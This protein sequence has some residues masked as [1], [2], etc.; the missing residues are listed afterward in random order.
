V[1]RSRT[2]LAASLAA[3]LLLVPTAVSAGECDSTPVAGA[4]HTAHEVVD[5]ALGT[6]THDLFE[7]AECAVHEV[8]ELLGLR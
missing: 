5:G 4:V 8:E 1:T 2:L 3:G 6:D 7:P